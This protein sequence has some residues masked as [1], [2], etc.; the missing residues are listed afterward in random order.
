MQVGDRTLEV[1]PLLT[2]QSRSPD[3]CWVAF[4]T[5]AIREGPERQLTG[6][7]PNGS[8]MSLLYRDDDR[9]ILTIDATDATGLLRMEAMSQIPNTVWSHLNTFAELRMTGGSQLEIVFSPCAD[10][11]IEIRLADYPR[12]RPARFAYVDEAGSFR[13]MEATSA[14][15]GPF[16][17]LASGTLGKTDPLAME[18]R[19]GGKP[20]FRVVLE[21][22]AQ[23]AS[24]QL[25]P[26]AGWGVAVNSIEFSLD[27]GGSAH[28]FV[29]LAA[30]SVGRGFDSVGHAAG[31]YRSRI[32]VEWLGEN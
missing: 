14:E 28:V 30:T 25:S 9:S 24:R 22:W 1:R 12:G 18:F 15:K 3:G 19:A 29:S 7:K 2:F 6:S 27:E 5:R 10:K 20:L 4:A 32:S 23:Q 31:V 8:K 21:D 17:E 13:V 11:V 16:R 26:T